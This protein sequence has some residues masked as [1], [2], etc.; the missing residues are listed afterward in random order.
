MRATI[1]D[2]QAK[3]WEGQGQ[4]DW[5]VAG[6]W[7]WAVIVLETSDTKGHI[8]IEVRCCCVLVRRLHRLQAVFSVRVGTYD[9]DIASSAVRGSW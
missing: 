1:G 5:S 4:T 8:A 9:G 2:K 7:Q 3:R 6:Q